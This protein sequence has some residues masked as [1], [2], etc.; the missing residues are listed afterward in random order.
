VATNDDHRRVALVLAGSR[1]MGRGSALALARQGCRIAI[2]GREV[3]SLETTRGELAALG[4]EPI[5]V[6]SDV[7]DADGLVE[8]VERVDDAYGRLDVLIANAGS[9]A[10]GPF[11]S[12]TDEDWEHAYQ[13]TLMSVVRS[14]RQ[15]IARM[16]D[17]GR[18]VVIGSS[19]VRRPIPN[20]TVS[21]ALRPALNGLVKSLAVELAPTGI[22]V[23]MVSPGRVDTDHARRSDERRA[24]ARNVSYEVV[25]AEYE[26]AIPMGRYGTAEEVGEMVAYLAGPGSGYI[27]GQS[28]L[29]DGGLVATLP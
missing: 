20:L 26:A 29:V 10:R 28:V 19:S 6:A 13:L 11:L 18:I 24:D 4:A 14:T 12:I 7:A 8:V 23:N 5:S 17:G 3:T 25:R 15:A 22:T 21:N 27:T 9:P 16:R 1:G 2:T